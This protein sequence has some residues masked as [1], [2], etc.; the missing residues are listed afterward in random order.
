MD[1]EDDKIEGSLVFKF[2]VGLAPWSGDWSEYTTAIDTEITVWSDDEDEAAPN[3]TVGRM[4]MVVVKLAEAVRDGTELYDVL[5]QKVLESLYKVLFKEDGVFW[6]HLDIQAPLGDL[7]V[8]EAVQV[9]SKYENTALH[10]HAI[11]TAI[12]TLASIG[13]VVIKK[14]VLR[15]SPSAWSDRG[16]VDLEFQN[17]LLLDNY[18]AYLE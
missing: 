3:V 13:I 11:E 6:P 15:L 12:Q 2:G 9:E 17:Y 5:D 10:Q 1:T 7:L 14:Q 4:K 18:K 16:Y 8:I